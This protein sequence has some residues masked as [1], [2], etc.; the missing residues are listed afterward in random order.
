MIKINGFYR[1]SHKNVRLLDYICC[2]F[3]STLIPVWFPCV[4]FYLS[5]YIAYLFTCGILLSFQILTPSVYIIEPTEVL[6][7][8]IV[9]YAPRYVKHRKNGRRNVNTDNSKN[10]KNKIRTKKKTFLFYLPR[11]YWNFLPNRNLRSD[12]KYTNHHYRHDDDNSSIT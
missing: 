5:L 6:Y 4:F 9:H 12:L 2:A 10:E 7:M 3:L 8:Y 1:I 11:L